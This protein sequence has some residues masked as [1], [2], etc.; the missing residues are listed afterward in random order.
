[1]DVIF[2]NTVYWF[3]LSSLITSS[4]LIGRAGQSVIPLR[5]LAVSR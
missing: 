5:V 2:M 1:V 3:E 4:W